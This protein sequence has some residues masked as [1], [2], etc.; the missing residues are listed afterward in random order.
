[1][2][3]RGLDRRS[4]R[5]TTCRVAQAPYRALIL[6]V[7]STQDP[8]SLTNSIR[9]TLAGDRPDAPARACAHARCRS[10]PTRSRR[11]NFRSFC[12][13]SSPRSRSCSPRRHLRRDVVP[14]RATHARDRR[15]HGTRRAA[16]RR[17]PARYR[18]R[19]AALIGA[20]TLLGFDRSRLLSTSLLRSVLYSV[21]ALDFPPSSSSPSR[22]PPSPLLASYLPARRAMRSD[23]MI[24]LGHG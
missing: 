19:A 5:N 10:S 12:S 23:P 4:R 3:H 2:H 7:R 9:Q 14:R 24:A 6:A 13:R 11:A 1:M 18:A 20:G 16:F 15:A 21:S 17:A 8:R 22:S